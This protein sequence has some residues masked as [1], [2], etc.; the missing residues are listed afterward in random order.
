[1]I[2]T[3]RKGIAFLMKKYNVEV[4]TE[5]RKFSTAR[6][7]RGERQGLSGKKPDYCDGSSAFI[8]PIPGVDSRRSSRTAKFCK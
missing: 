1:V 8:P 6:T 5:M 7:V 2:E 3:L 4:V